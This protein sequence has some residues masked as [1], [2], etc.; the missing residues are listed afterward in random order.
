MQRHRPLVPA[1]QIVMPRLGAEMRQVDQCHPVRRPH[2]QNLPRRHRQQPLPRPQHRQRA[3]QPL[4]IQFLIP[5]QTALPTIVTT[6]QG[7][8]AALPL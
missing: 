5:V 8:A 3:Q 2:G 7:D 6:V 1:S 4:A